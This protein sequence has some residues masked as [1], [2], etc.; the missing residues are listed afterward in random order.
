MWNMFHS[1]IINWHSY[2]KYLV[3][4]SNLYSISINEL[5]YTLSKSN[6][7]GFNRL[8]IK[9]YFLTRCLSC[10]NDAIFLNQHPTYMTPGCVY[11]Q[12]TVIGYVQIWL[13]SMVYSMNLCCNET[14]VAIPW[15]F[16]Y[17]VCV[18]HTKTSRNALI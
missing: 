1:K 5:E 18:Q 11:D 4:W 3:L 8:F 12:Y 13:Y 6:M 9:I 2:F 17:F 7:L 14:T 10:E 16:D 15:L